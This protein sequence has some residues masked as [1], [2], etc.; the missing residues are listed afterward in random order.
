MGKSI[1][2]GIAISCIAAVGWSIVAADLRFGYRVLDGVEAERV[3]EDSGG[4]TGETVGPVVADKRSSAMVIVIGLEG[5]SKS[6]RTGVPLIF[7]IYPHFG[8]RDNGVG[9]AEVTENRRS[10]VA[11][12]VGVGDIRG[13]KPGGVSTVKIVCL[14][15]GGADVVDLKTVLFV[16]KD[17]LSLQGTMVDHS[18]IVGGDTVGVLTVRVGAVVVEDCAGR[19][20]LAHLVLEVDAS[21]QI[22]V[23]EAHVVETVVAEE[24]TVVVA[25]EESD[26]MAEVGDGERAVS[27]RAQSVDRHRREGSVVAHGLQLEGELVVA[28]RFSIVMYETLV[29]H[30][31]VEE[32]G[33]AINIDDSGDAHYAIDDFSQV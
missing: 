18:V 19:D 11:D 15:I 30:H 21:L 1:G 8:D 4:Q 3:V 9:D 10:A 12:T 5:H 26:G 31:V 32:G 17:Q 29:R 16:F 23:V 22:V 14:T 7:A 6:F 27:T 20:N 2:D 25:F 28:E 24:E 33:V 13:N